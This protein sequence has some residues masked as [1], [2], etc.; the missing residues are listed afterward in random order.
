MKLNLNMEIDRVVGGAIAICFLLLLASG[1]LIYDRELARKIPATAEQLEVDNNEL[2]AE[3]L[4]LI[5]ASALEPLP[6]YWKSI[7]QL[8]DLY[9]LSMAI[10][11]TPQRPMY[12]GVLF[13]WHGSLIGEKS[14]LLAALRQ[15]QAVAPVY[16]YD[17]TLENQN[18]TV[19]FSVVGADQ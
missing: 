14:K 19:Y 15:I 7:V 9:D 4:A 11:E 12:S 3:K 13:A 16:L 6:F 5:E 8:A 10:I 2:R 17:I 18:G 1:K